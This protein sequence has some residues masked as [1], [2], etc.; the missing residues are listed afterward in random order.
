MKQ[1]NFLGTNKEIKE[2]NSIEKKE[3]NEEFKL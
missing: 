1:L 3:N 2:N